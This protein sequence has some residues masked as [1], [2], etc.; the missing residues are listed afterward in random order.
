VAPREPRRYASCPHPRSLTAFKDDT[1]GQ[2]TDV[3]HIP[4]RVKMPGVKTGTTASIRERPATPS[5]AGQA[6]GCQLEPAGR[7]ISCPVTKLDAPM[8]N[9]DPPRP[10][11]VRV[12]EFPVAASRRRPW[13]SPL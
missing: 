8:A 9:C 10:G 4:D 3:T 13:L 11:K 2:A 5:N 7:L 12:C 6:G 1:F